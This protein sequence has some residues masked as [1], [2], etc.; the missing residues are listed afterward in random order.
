MCPL[1]LAATSTFFSF[2]D[3]MLSTACLQSMHTFRVG[4]ESVVEV[5]EDRMLAEVAGV[6]PATELGRS[7]LPRVLDRLRFVLKQVCITNFQVI[8]M[9][10]RRDSEEFV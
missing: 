9:R 5:S 7:Y 1:S 10:L 3:F 4:L 8:L 6:S 2:D